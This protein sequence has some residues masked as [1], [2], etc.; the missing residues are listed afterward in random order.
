MTGRKITGLPLPETP[1]EAPS[2]IHGL[3]EAIEVTLSDADAMEAA[4]VLGLIFDYLTR[5]FAGIAGAAAAHLKLSGDGSV[6]EDFEAARRQLKDRMDALGEKATDPLSK[7]VRGVFYVGA[8]R[9]VPTPR[10]HARLLDLGGIPIRGYRN[11]AE[12][13]AI[14]PGT[15]DLSNES[16]ANRELMRYLP[17]LKEWL[18]ATATY[19]LDSRQSEPRWESPNKLYFTVEA[20]D[21]TLEVGPIYIPEALASLLPRDFRN[22]QVT[23]PEPPV[24]ESTP[25]IASKPPEDIGSAPSDDRLPPD[26][27]DTSA[28]LEASTP[29]EPET[30]EPEGAKPEVFEETAASATEAEPAPPPATSPLPPVDSTVALRREDFAL[31]FGDLAPSVAPVSS[32]T[33]ANSSDPLEPVGGSEPEPSEKVPETT[34]PVET[35]ELGSDNP[36]APRPTRLPEPTVALRVEDLPF[37]VKALAAT[38]IP[39]V[40]SAPSLEEEYPLPDIDLGP[41]SSPAQAEDTSPA[42]GTVEEPPNI[43]AEEVQAPSVSQPDPVPDSSLSAAVDEEPATPELKSTRVPPVLFKDK[44][45]ST[46]TITVAPPLQLYPVVT[47][48]PPEF[49]DEV[50]VDADYPEVLQTALTDLNGAI[51]ANDSLLICGQMQRCFDLMIQFF[52][53]IAASVLQEIDADQLFDFDIEDGRFDLETKLELLVTS[54]SALEEY[55]EGHDAATLIWAVFYDT[56]LPATD[57]NSAYLHTRLLGVEG[58]V[59]ATFTEF[60]ELCKIVPGQGVLAERSACRETAHRY[61]PILGFWLEN[62][63]PLFLESE[64]DFVEEE[65][66]DALSWAASVSGSTLDGTPSGLWLEVSPSRWNLPRPELAPVFVVGDAPDVLLPVT[67]ELNAALEKKDFARAGVMVRV[68]LDFLIQYFAGCAAALWREQGEMSGQAEEL[69]HPTATLEEKERLLMLSLGSISAASAVGAGLGKLFSKGSVQYR[70]LSRREVPQGMDVVSEWAVRRDE[71][72]ESELLLY[73]PLLR[74]WLGAANPWFGAGEQLF[75][76][77]TSDGR[78]EGVV[79]FGDDFLEM[80]DPEYVIALAPELMELLGTSIEALE[81]EADEE[82][83]GVA[84]P[85]REFTGELPPIPI[86]TNGPP[87]LMAHLS[88]LFEAGDDRRAANAWL[89]SAFE[90]LIQYFAGLLTT[91]LGGKEAPI[92]AATLEH[93]QPKA[94]LRERELL[95]TEAIHILK[96]SAAGETQEMLR[97]VFVDATGHFRRHARYLGVEGAGSLSADEM[98]LSFWCRTRHRTGTLNTEEYHFA[99]AALSGWIEAA[100]PFF[101]ASEHYAEDPGA[102]G[103]EEMVVELAEDYLDMVLPDYAIQVPARGYYEILYRE[104]ETRAADEAATYFPEDVRPELLG[105]RSDELGGIADGTDDMLLGAATVELGG[106][107]LFGGAAGAYDSDDLFSGPKVTPQ[108][109]AK[110]AVVDSPYQRK[111]RTGQVKLGSDPESEKTSVL[112]L[113]SS[114]LAEAESEAADRRRRKK[115]AKKTELGTAV[116]ELYKKERLEKARKRAEARARKE[117][118]EPTRL[119]YKLSYRGLKNSKQLGGRCHF[120]LIEI[121]NSGGGQLKGTVEP[122]HPSVKVQPSRFEGNEVRVVYQIDP[123]DMPSTGRVGISLNTQDQ[124]IELRMERLVPTSWARERSFAEA[125]GLSLAPVAAYAAWLLILIGAVFGPSLT[126]AFASLAKGGTLATSVKLK[127]W[128]FSMLAILPGSTGVPAAMKM[129]FSQWEF[130]VQEELRKF[131]PGMMMF[132]TFTMIAV[133]YGTKLWQFSALADNLPFLAARFWF[134]VLTMGLNLLAASLFSLQ[135]TAWW[136]DNADTAIAKRAF[137]GFWL[138]TVVI[139]VL[140]TFGMA[141]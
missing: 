125:L 100:R 40:G 127:L 44:E 13:I 121:T 64:V 138:A 132:P 23:P 105:P 27:E 30:S 20:E 76:E 32:V 80:V 83:L 43:V 22:L 66:G 94:S 96:E 81:E 65:R 77:P 67:D 117:E 9:S 42:S 68:A 55:W 29:A 84:E 93:F 14:A 3:V 88:R 45:K 92:R 46:G 60:S 78:L 69:Y 6:A 71:V 63:T 103:Q 33:A 116:L 10:R 91:V 47:G 61:L 136:E 124:R 50:P 62:A 95:L 28:P 133:M 108:A 102:D 118:S 34:A 16:K 70:A 85:P 17:I 123:S 128:L 38:N 109:E 110:P 99:M 107:D 106:D 73:L 135:T 18:T 137:Y 52:A 5:Y 72:S 141:W 24:A 25:I 59:P 31:D 53:G 82:E 111:P 98:L 79:A 12:W 112:P 104:I 140:A 122:S 89:G 1:K 15:G 56:L 19:F 113:D 8:T 37:D 49:F 51:E 2:E 134:I 35:P 86:L 120:G 41:A 7:L 4:Q 101:S 57:P 36:F 130:S 39:V 126:T 54:L 119:D 131:L 129:M 48:P 74:S 115:R 90:Y 114:A 58:L 75:E 21:A 11:I 139:G 87:L 26:S 97:D